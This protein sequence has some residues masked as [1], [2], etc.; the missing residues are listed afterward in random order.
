MTL[1]VFVLVLD[2]AGADTF[3]DFLMLLEILIE[4]LDT[5]FIGAHHFLIN[6]WKAETSLLE[7]YHIAKSLKEFGIDE[8]LLKVLGGW[9]I[10]IERVAVDDEE[11]DG[12]VHLR[13]G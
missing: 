1:Q 11:A 6:V 12:L 3:E 10:G 8:N 9:I 2:D 5:D 4:V 13:G 7:R